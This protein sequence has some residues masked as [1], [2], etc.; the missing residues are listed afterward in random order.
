MNVYEL[1]GIVKKCVVAEKVYKES[2]LGFMSD[3]RLEE[4]SEY[5]L[6]MCVCC[7]SKDLQKGDE[8]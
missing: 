1:V 7:I 6:C 2:A 4:M 5:I 8:L 3:V